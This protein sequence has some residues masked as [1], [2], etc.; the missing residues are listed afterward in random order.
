[1]AYSLDVDSFLR[2]REAYTVID[3]LYDMAADLRAFQ[4][5]TLSRVREVQDV[6]ARRG[7]R[8]ESEGDS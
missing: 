1:V 2:S 4:S 8:G 7:I 5:S 6:L 3:G